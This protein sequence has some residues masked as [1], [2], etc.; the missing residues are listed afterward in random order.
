MTSRRGFIETVCATFLSM[1][2]MKKPAVHFRSRIIVTTPESAWDQAGKS[3]EEMV[4]QLYLAAK[5]MKVEGNFT[6]HWTYSEP[7]GGWRHARPILN[8]PA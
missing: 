4:K 2:G 1:F 6:S 3:K 5:K 8:D 7:L